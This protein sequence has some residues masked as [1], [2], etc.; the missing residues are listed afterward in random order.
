MFITVA[1]G[2]KQAQDLA[3]LVWEPLHVVLTVSLHLDS[4]L[5]S[6]CQWPELQEGNFITVDE[7]PFCRLLCGSVAWICTL[8]MHRCFLHVIFIKLILW[9]VIMSQRPWMLPL[10]C[11]LPLILL[12][13]K[14]KVCQLPFISDVPFVVSL[15]DKIFSITLQNIPERKTT[16]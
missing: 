13:S 10:H 2:G 11:I 4:L 5:R 14:H 16:A 9:D 6:I 12:D 15:V 3:V 1:N 7:L 8:N